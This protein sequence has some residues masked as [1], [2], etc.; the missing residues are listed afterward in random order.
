MPPKDKAARWLK[1]NSA[2]VI[3]AIGL[4]L[5]AINDSIIGLAIYAIVIHIL[6]VSFTVGLYDDRFLEAERVAT[7][8]KKN[9][10]KRHY[11][12]VAI[13]IIL[14]SFAIVVLTARGHWYLVII[15]IV[16]MIMLAIHI[17]DFLQRLGKEK[18]K[19]VM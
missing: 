8:A 17:A 15:T 2:L 14:C 18:K 11:G 16:T 12:V 19:V 9:K 13:A 10:G 3:A 4:I 6:C 5:M 1:C 7:L